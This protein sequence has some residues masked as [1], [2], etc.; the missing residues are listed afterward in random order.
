MKDFE[1]IEA[2]V[3]FLRTRGYL[4]LCI[5][6]WPEKT[7]HKRPEIDA[8]AGAFAIEHTSV[9]TLPNRRRNADW[10]TQAIGGLET[11][12][13]KPPTCRLS[14]A[15]ESYAVC[16]SQDWRAIRQTLKAWI[17]GTV[18]HLADGH[19]AVK[20]IPGVPFRLH[21]TKQH[22]VKIRWR[23]PFLLKAV[24]NSSTANL[25]SVFRSLSAGTNWLP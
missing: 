23:I 10:F 11:E 12:L 17:T 7:N 21:V 9:D 18:L 2:F 8:L 24:S 14:I 15:V 20:D 13:A 4:G 19:H 5:D 25:L 1:V 16:R 6:S 3:A 22:S